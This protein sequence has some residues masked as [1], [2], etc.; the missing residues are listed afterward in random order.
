VLYDLKRQRLVPIDVGIPTFPYGKNWQ[1]F[2]IG[3]DLYV[4]HELTP[5][6]VLRINIDNGGADVVREDDVSFKLPAFHQPYP[7]FRGGANALYFDA[8]LLGVGKATSQRYRHHPFFWSMDTGGGQLQ[9]LFTEFF[10]DFHKCGFN[11]VDPTSLFFDGEDIFLGLCCSERDWV[12]T[13]VVS[14]FLIALRAAGVRGKHRLLSHFFDERAIT[15]ERGV[16]NLDRHM[17]FCVEM[18]T[19]AAGVTDSRGRVS[20]GEAGYLVHGPGVEIAREGRYWAELSYLTRSCSAHRA[21]E[22]D[23]T[24]SV[25]DR[26]GKQVDFRTLALVDLAA[27]DGGMREARLEF[28]TA[29]L[30][31]A[32]LETRVL[33]EE[34]V[35]LIAFHVRTWRDDH[36]AARS[37]FPWSGLP[38]SSLDGNEPTPDERHTAG[39]HMHGRR[40][41]RIHDIR[42]L[43]PLPKCPS[44]P[45]EWDLIEGLGAE[46]LDEP[47]VACGQRM[48]RLVAV[49]SDGRHAL[50]AR[51][52]GLAPGAVYR[53]M[54]WIRAEPAAHV[55]IEVRDSV[56]THTGQPSNY[57]VAHFNP[58]ARSVTKSTG[59]ILAS[60]VDTAADG[61]LRVWADLRS[62]DGQIVVLIGLLEG[63]NDKHVF[64]G[65]GQEVTFGGFEIRPGR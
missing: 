11:I 42:E 8:A 37:A 34:G 23:V 39:G 55:M 52:G 41:A 50:S 44:G 31:G 2:L 16:P 32:K 57:G 12:H 35:E 7:M 49:P 48:L 53:A 18:P 13:Q 46:M 36:A 6:R 9:I 1:P 4:V 20:G 60:G 22:F 38:R 27:T 62:K 29:G 45:D 5:F 26:D 30:L 21:G 43:P 56:D 63:S 61:W 19:A 40:Q 59:D 58:A 14:H 10:Y 54:S 15:E 28:D 24:V 25:S 47:A 33:V 3:E 65:R 64:K 51:F 17:F